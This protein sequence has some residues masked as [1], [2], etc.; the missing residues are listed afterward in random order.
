MAPASAPRP[1]KSPSANPPP[2]KPAAF[3]LV[4]MLVVI[5]IVLALVALLAPAFTTLRNAGDV[6]SAAYAIKGALEQARIY[7]V[8]NGTYTWVGFY[9]ENTSA[10]APTNVAPPY[11][12][13]G[14]LLMAS[15]F[16]TDGT[17]IFEDTDPAAPLPAARFKQ[18]GKLVRIE[19]V[20]VT[21]VGPPPSP[22]PSPTPSPDKFDG[23]PRLPYTDG[24]P[25]D[26]Y[27]RISSDNPSGTQVSGDQARFPFSVQ[28][29]TFYKEVRFSPRGEATINGT[30]GL[31]HTA[32][33]GLVQTHGDTAP[34]PPPGSNTYSGNAVAIQFNGI[35]GQFRIYTR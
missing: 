25:F 29:Y 15:I 14:R 6:T 12:G 18:I 8:A 27:N 24:A 5:G 31:K 11:P 9:E 28:N 2:P 23:R 20:H 1:L 30:Y 32:E 16:S 4:E 22:A 17:K 19:G 33:I 13:K 34:T 3:T 35:A 7:A 21:D 10:A 26:H